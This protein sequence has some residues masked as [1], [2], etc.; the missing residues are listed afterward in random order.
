MTLGTHVAFAS[1][2][3]L[4]GAT[5]WTATTPPVTEAASCACTLRPR[6]QAPSVARSRRRPGRG[7][8]AVLAPA[9]RGGGDAGAGGGAAGGGTDTGAVEAV[10][11]NAPLQ[12]AR[13]L[14]RVPCKRRL[15]GVS[16]CLVMR[17][18]S[19]RKQA[20]PMAFEGLPREER[21]ERG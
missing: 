16:V 9:R 1:V 20:L 11:V 12:G 21:P 8:G 13:R 7:G 17:R 10:F 6:S 14:R 3:Y 18:P 5:A 2:L 19:G 15:G 4:A